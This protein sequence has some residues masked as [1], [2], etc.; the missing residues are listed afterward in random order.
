MSSFDQKSRELISKAEQG[1]WSLAC[2]EKLLD[3]MKDVANVSLNRDFRS[4][5]LNATLSRLIVNLQKIESRSMATK[6]N[7]STMMINLDETKV[8]L[9]NLTRINSIKNTNYCENL[10]KDDHLDEPEDDTTQKKTVSS[11]IASYSFLKEFN[12]YLVLGQIIAPS[13]H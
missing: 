5:S 12:Q 3:L 13:C 4:F 11:N 1:E 6:G 8:R 7:L 2:D 10:I 9:S